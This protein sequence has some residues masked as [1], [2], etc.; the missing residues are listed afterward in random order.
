MISLLFTPYKQQTDKN[1]SHIFDTLAQRLFLL[2]DEFSKEILVQLGLAKKVE[3]G[4]NAIENIVLR[5]KL[6]Y[7]HFLLSTASFDFVSIADQI[8]QQKYMKEEN[9]IMFTEIALLIRKLIS[10]NT[11]LKNMK[12]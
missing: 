9:A 3:N 4:S 12:L 7:L 11:Q 5:D 8:S 2:E 10:S 1:L 6:Y